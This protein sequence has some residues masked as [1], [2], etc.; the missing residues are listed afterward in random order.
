MAAKKSKKARSKKPRTAAQRAATAKMIAANKRSGRKSGGT[1]RKSSGVSAKNMP[2]RVLERRVD[3]LESSLDGV[4]R[5][6][7]DHGKRLDGH[8]A[9][10]IEASKEMDNINRRVKGLEGL[11]NSLFGSN[12]KSTF[13]G[14][15]GPKAGYSNVVLADDPMSQTEARARARLS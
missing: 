11:T 13:T 8:D 15:S 1:K 12:A 4:R 9:F 5:K 7:N 2:F 6:T 3:A 10:V 14:F